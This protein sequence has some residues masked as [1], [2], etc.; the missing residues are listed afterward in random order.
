MNSARRR[1]SLACSGEQPR[2][3]PSSSGTKQSQRGKPKQTSFASYALPDASTTVSCHPDVRPGRRAVR[4]RAPL[5]VLCLRRS[6]HLYVNFVPLSYENGTSSS[7]ELGIRRPR[8]T[9]STPARR[10]PARLEDAPIR[11][12][13]NSN[14]WA[15][16]QR[17]PSASTRVGPRPVVQAGF[18]LL[19]SPRRRDSTESLGNVHENRLCR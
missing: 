8:G 13:V 16:H 3:R 2:G 11:P 7:V 6:C 1:L 19:H 17:P 15:A 10:V 5:V 4:T 18:H 12:D 14:R 9:L